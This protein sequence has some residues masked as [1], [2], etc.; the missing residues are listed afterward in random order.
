MDIYTRPSESDII[1]MAEKHLRGYIIKGHEIIADQCPFCHG[2]ENKDKRTFF[3]SLQTG[4]YICHRG[5]CGRKGGFPSLLRHFGES[6]RPELRTLKPIAM[7]PLCRTNQ[8]D[9]YFATRHISRET[10]DAFQVGADFNGNIVF[11]FYV[12]GELIY[13]KYRKPK[14]PLPGDRFKEWQQKDAQPVLFGMDMCVPE[15]PLIITEG[16]I[17][18]LSVYEAGIRNVVSVPCGCENF[19]WVEPCFEWLEKFQRIIIF[20]D[21]DAPGR[22]MVKTLS[23]RIGEERC[24]VI[25]QYPEGCKDAND[26]LIA[27]GIVGLRDAVASAHEVPIRG[28]LNLADVEYV[29]PTTVPRIRTMI[30]QLDESL[31][32][33]EEGAV[34][35]ITGE[36]GGGK[37]TLSGMFLLNAI[38]QGHT[39]CAVSGELSASKFQEWID[40]QAAGSEWITLKYDP[41]KGKNVPVVFP[42]AAQRIHAWYD[43]KFFLF[44]SNE[45]LTASIADS[46]IA[47]F[48]M[49]AKRK[50]C[51]LFLVDNIMSS[52][53]DATDEENRAQGRFIGALK[54]FSVRYAA[55]VL[56]VAHPRKTKAGLPISKDD[57]GGNKMITNLASNA[58]VVEKPDLRIIK[59][60]D[61][62]FTRKIEC[63][64]CGDS[65]RIYQASAGDLNTFSWNRE[66]LKAPSVRADSMPEYG[67]QL[68]QN[69]P[70]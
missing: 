35:V 56:V 68:S 30:P 45:E 59:A 58:I 18:A 49:A 22:K 50:G 48:T 21:D 1:A 42:P 65:R 23:T 39:V 28:L 14:P 38:E 26:I 8:I 27:K 63:C 37:S 47:V 2:G 53:M 11:P 43:K 5:K 25:D 33:L 67:I 41:V 31:N 36:S 20:G 6:T 3:I 62:G 55:H 29:D 46:I 52:L 66:G 69:Q 24:S 15:E 61:C 12:E 51:K 32:G 9:E 19:E 57:V 17:D 16:E 64:Y 13:A 60:R 34:T 10:L 70:F 7:T 44:D 4:Q 40:L 54:R